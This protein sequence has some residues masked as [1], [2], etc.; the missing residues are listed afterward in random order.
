MPKKIGARKTRNFPT[1]ISC[2]RL[3]AGAAQT[4]D[5]ECRWRKAL[6]AIEESIAKKEGPKEKELKEKFSKV[7]TGV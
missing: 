2:G 1:Q 7:L 3:A 4:R 6:C 5:E